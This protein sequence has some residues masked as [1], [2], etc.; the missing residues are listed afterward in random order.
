MPQGDWTVNIF[1]TE[2]YSGSLL[3]EAISILQMNTQTEFARTFPDRR[4]FSGVLGF[5][6]CLFL[7]SVCSKCE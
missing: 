5:I 3:L 6:F 2:R 7:G 4:V 1:N